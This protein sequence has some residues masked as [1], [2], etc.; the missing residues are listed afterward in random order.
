MNKLLCAL[1]CLPIF[2]SFAMEPDG[3]SKDLP[4]LVGLTRTTRVPQDPALPRV[5]API[6][7]TESPA[8]KKAISDKDKI[9]NTENKGGRFSPTKKESNSP[10]Q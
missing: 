2:S 7:I 8:F 3:K 4:K 5:T 1:I 9:I 10:R 6:S